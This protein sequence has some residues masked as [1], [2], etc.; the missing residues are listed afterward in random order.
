MPNHSMFI[1]TRPGRSRP[2][3]VQRHGPSVA[4]SIHRAADMC[5]NTIDAI[6]LA[7]PAGRRPDALHF[8]PAL[9]PWTPDLATGTN[10]SILVKPGRGG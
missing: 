4:Q 2:V 3:K 1:T 7:Q 9:T 5:T 10:V 6:S 8:R